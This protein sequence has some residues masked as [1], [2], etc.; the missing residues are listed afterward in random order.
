MTI[1]TFTILGN[2]TRD[3]EL[4][5]TSKGTP[6]A[7]YA[8]A[9]NN[10]WY[11]EAGRHEQTDFIPVT[12]YGNQAQ[13]DARF[14][15]KGSSVSVMGRIRSWYKSDEKKGGFKFEAF[16]VEYLGSRS[17]NAATQAADAD[18]VAPSNADDSEHAQWV[19]DYENAALGRNG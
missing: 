15:K 1:N 4:R 5:Y 6:V 14:L 13:S 19:R 17:Q 12:T 10:H 16:Q 3:I 9:V 7:T 18:R 11:D 8:V 2:L